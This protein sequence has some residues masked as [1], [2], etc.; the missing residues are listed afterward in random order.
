LKRRNE[1]EISWIRIV[2]W[3]RSLKNKTVTTTRLVAYRNSHLLYSC[4]VVS[5]TKT[6]ANNKDETNFA[7]SF[8]VERSEWSF[9]LKSWPRSIGLTNSRVRVRVPIQSTSSSPTAW[10]SQSKSDREM[11]SKKN[12]IPILLGLYI[13]I[14]AIH[15]LN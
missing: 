6:E 14:S 4:F 10:A 9:Q 5:R 8:K 3:E 1:N 7:L 11:E 12:N 13:I 15:S 2:V